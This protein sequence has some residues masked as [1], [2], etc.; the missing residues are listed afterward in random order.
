M[1]ADDFTTRHRRQVG[2]LAIAHGTRLAETLS[3]IEADCG[4][5]DADRECY[6]KD[7]GLTYAD[8]VRQV[9]QAAASLLRTGGTLAGVD[10][11]DRLASA[12]PPSVKLDAG[13]DGTPW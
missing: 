9:R 5:I 4:V 6:D 7:E 12:D 3:M 11:S 2:L 13:D 1:T 8:A 10:V